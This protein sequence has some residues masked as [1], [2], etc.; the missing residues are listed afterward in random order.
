HLGHLHG[1]YGEAAGVRIARKHLGW[2]AKDR[3]EHVAFRAVVN[4]AQTAEEQLRL[5]RD[6][7]DALVAGVVPEL[8]VAA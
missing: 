7:F 2:Y 1:F 4:R 5:T 3:P 6:Y 8:S